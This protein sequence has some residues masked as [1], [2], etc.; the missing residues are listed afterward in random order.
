M[1]KAKMTFTL[2]IS[3]IS[4]IVISAMNGPLSGTISK[5]EEARTMAEK[6]INRYFVKCG[7][8]WH[9]LSERLGLQFIRNVRQ[10]N[11]NGSL[12]ITS[13]ELSEADKLNGYEYKG[14]FLMETNGPSRAFV[15]QSK[16]W[17]EWEDT[18]YDIRFYVTRKNG[19]WSTKQMYGKYEPQNPLR[20]LEKEEGY[21]REITCGDVN[22]ILDVPTEVLIEPVVP[23][24]AVAVKPKA[25]GAPQSVPIAILEKQELI[26]SL[27]ETLSKITASRNAGIRSEKQKQAEYIHEAWKLL[28]K[29][30]EAQFDGSIDNSIQQ[31]IGDAYITLNEARNRYISPKVLKSASA[32]E[33][34]TIKMLKGVLKELESR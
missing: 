9:C 21:Y 1:K 2:V 3:V 8:Y 11:K 6:V 32:K 22:R 7:E 23:E 19:E 33:A 5:N 16:K 15:L 24:G 30:N 13:Q 14:E 28:S 26:N 18:R 31:R 4:L 29:I 27:K 34:E 10:F 25:G 12:S 20:Y 17:T